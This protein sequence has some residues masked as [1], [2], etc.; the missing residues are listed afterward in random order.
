MPGSTMPSGMRAEGPLALAE[1]ERVVAEAVDC[2]R[3]E[4]AVAGRLGDSLRVPGVLETVLAGAFESKC[5]AH[6]NVVSVSR[7]LFIP[8]TNLCRD[9]CA[10][11]T[12]AKLP[13]D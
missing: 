7:N 2:G 10:Y 9:R 11:C 1:A 5:R 6:G 4:A 8:L 13:D 12:F 3:L